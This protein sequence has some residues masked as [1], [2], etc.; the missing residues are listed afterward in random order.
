MLEKEFFRQKIEEKIS[1]DGI[2]ERGFSLK[3]LTFVQIRNKDFRTHF[4]LNLLQ[5]TGEINEFFIT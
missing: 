4:P 2:S 3:L 5:L 1:D